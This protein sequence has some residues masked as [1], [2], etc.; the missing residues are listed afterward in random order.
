MLL[1]SGQVWCMHYK[2]EQVL[3]VLLKIGTGLMH[4]V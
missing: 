2:E 3:L 1:Q 4:A